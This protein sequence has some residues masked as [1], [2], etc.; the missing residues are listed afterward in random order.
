M[1]TYLFIQTYTE[2]GGDFVE[3]FTS[4]YINIHTTH[5]HGW[6]LNTKSWSLILILEGWPGALEAL[7]GGL[8]ALSGGLKVHSG[9]V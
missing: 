6:H 1:L 5:G 7:P 9:D 8:E 4:P 3:K 2:V